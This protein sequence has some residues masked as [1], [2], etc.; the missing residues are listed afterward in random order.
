MTETPG[1]KGPWLC[2]G[3]L[4]TPFSSRSELE[5]FLLRAEPLVDRL[6]G[7]DVMVAEARQ[8]LGALSPAAGET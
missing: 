4:P 7:L 8:R 3:D 6:E 1:Q 5:G 2:G